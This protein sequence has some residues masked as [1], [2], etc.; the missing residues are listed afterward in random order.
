MWSSSL[1]V[2]MVHLLFMAGGGYMVYSSDWLYRAIIFTALILFRIFWTRRLMASAADAKF[3][4]V[5]RLAQQ[6]RAA[7]STRSHSQ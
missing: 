3:S 7:I 6:R 1:G 4:E 2:W 5:L